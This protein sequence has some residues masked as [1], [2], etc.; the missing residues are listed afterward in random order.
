MKI[1]N[2]NKIPTVE[3]TIQ[4][5]NTEHAEKQYSIRGNGRSYGDA[6]LNEHI[7]STDNIKEHLSIDGN[8]LHISSGYILRDALLFCFKN[9]YLFPVIPG[10]QY[11]SIGGMIAAD[12][13]GKNHK[14][15]GTLG[16][17]IESLELQLPN[18]EITL[19]STAEN[20]ELFNITIG[21]MGLSGTILSAHIRLEKL[22]GNSLEQT[23]TSS[24]SF[25]ELLDKLDTSTATYQVAWVDLLNK[26]R[27]FL[28]EA[29]FSNSEIIPTLSSP[30]VTVPALG[31]SFLNRTSIRLYNWYHARNLVRKK[32]QNVKFSSFFFPLD[33]INHW[34]RLYGKKGFY[35]YQ[36]V[37]PK[38]QAKEG[39][40]TIIQRI[41][42]SRF[43]P[44][45]TVLKQHGM[46]HSPGIMS[47]P[48]DGYS[49]AIDFKNTNGIL[50]FFA[51]LDQLVIAFKGRVYLAKDARLN[52]E[53]FNKM[54]PKS[55]DF[56]A[57]IENINPGTVQSFLS[58]RL[59]LVKE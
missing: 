47:F 43:T 39:M 34:N 28:M 20:V 48:V 33:S 55:D 11:A 2:W 37:L 36:F 53:A 52:V 44:Y 26:N 23:I 38:D 59:L 22:E 58:K 14:K 21:G 10:T 32:Q 46:I 42:T 56:R 57:A 5:F 13:H 49:L 9:N 41:Q 45:L 51:E 54:Y 3:A 25:S 24:N 1:S 19:C 31:I 35:Q 30:K 12:V 7:Q 29:N 18:G 50:T 8:I 6:S 40:E 4:Q 27:N 16:N 17:W 15:N